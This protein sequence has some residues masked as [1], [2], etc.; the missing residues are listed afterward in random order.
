MSTGSAGLT[1]GATSPPSSSFFKKKRGRF[2]EAGYL[3]PGPRRRGPLK[4]K[5]AR[6]EQKPVRPAKTNDQ[7]RHPPRWRVRQRCE[8]EFKKC[9]NQTRHGE[10]RASEDCTHR[11][12]ADIEGTRAPRTHWTRCTRSMAC[13]L[14]RSARPTW[15]SK[16]Q[17]RRMR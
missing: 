16:A 4:S 1:S 15:S 12:V 8:H 13:T 11:E 10:R 17:A 3:R 7:N 5:Q 2:Y 9:K 14:C 6:G